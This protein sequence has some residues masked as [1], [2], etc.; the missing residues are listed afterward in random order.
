MPLHKNYFE[1]NLS[2]PRLCTYCAC[3]CES[4]EPEKSG[5]RGVVGTMGRGCYYR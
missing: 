1:H 3:V 2:G 4:S 5:F